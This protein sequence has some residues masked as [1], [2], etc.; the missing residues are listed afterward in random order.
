MVNTL[1][2]PIAYKTSM[3]KILSI[4]PK[5]PAT[6]ID[7]IRALLVDFLC[8]DNA[9]E[10]VDRLYRK[11]IG[12]VDS[13]TDVKIMFSSVSCRTWFT[14]MRFLLRRSHKT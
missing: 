7:Y 3:N 2:T 5:V 8:D 1:P 4:D 13:L 11:S 6:R 12:L 10:V 9:T 14:L